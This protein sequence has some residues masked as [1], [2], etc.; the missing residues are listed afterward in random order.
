MNRK[1]EIDPVCRV[2]DQGNLAKV[3]RHSSASRED[4]E[5]IRDFCFQSGRKDAWQFLLQKAAQRDRRH[6]ELT[7]RFFGAV[8]R[9]TNGRQ[10]VTA[11]MLSK[12]ISEFDNPRLF[13][14]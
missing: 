12:W 13:S 10:P 11:A 1:D 2:D 8:A 6:R 5:I 7:T 3:F 14:E 9:E 4:A